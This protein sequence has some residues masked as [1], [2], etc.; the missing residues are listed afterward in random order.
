M[1]KIKS[2]MQQ[3][4]RSPKEFPVEMALGVVFFLIAVYGTHKKGWDA[5]LG[6]LTSVV[7]TDIL[8]F[9]VP[10]GILSFYLGKVN[11]WAYWLSFLLFIPLMALNLDPFIGSTAFLFTYVLAAILLVIGRRRM[12]NPSFGAHVLHVV[13]QGAFGV[14]ISG[15]LLLAL[16]AIFG[17]VEYIFGLDYG[18]L[19]LY[20]HI[21]QFVGFVV[22]PQICC[23]LIAHGEDEEPL[24]SRVLQ[25]IL[26]FIVSPAIIIY[27]V[28]LYVYF[29]KIAIEWDLPKGGVALMVMAFIAVS[30]AGRLLQEVL[31]RRYYDWFYKHFTWIALPP[32]LMYWIGSIYR[33]RHYSFTEGRFYLLV[34]GVLMTLFVLMLLKE[35]SRRFQLMVLIFGIAIIVFTYIPGISA[36]SIGFRC[37]ET[38][39]HQFID[40]LKL[41]D[42]KTGKFREIFD[43]QKIAR[44]SVLS[45]RFQEAI[46]IIEY[47]R[48][49]MGRKEFAKQ[50]GKWEL[51]TYEVAYKENAEDVSPTEFER[52]QA[53]DL[54]AYPQLLPKTAYET[55]Y[56]EGVVTVKMDE[57]LVMRYPID[58]LVQQRP[59]L[60]QKPDD[61][62][63]CRNDSLLLVLENVRISNHHVWDVGTWETHLFR[64]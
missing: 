15:L 17:S 42:P 46:S 14:V 38:R 52:K 36:K 31:P 47:V 40:E 11:R 41:N 56:S 64:K 6:S 34:A 32:L 33:I 60:L 45:S 4:L 8:A 51:T 48:A 18:P 35:R 53:V 20:E 37:Q 1:S 49:G 19:H 27:T 58:S 39:L 44:D 22:A 7:N 59:E 25:I 12:D 28:I 54:R 63:V 29:I 43:R 50:Y 26:N 61:I 21:W 2:L 13:T 57:R 24:T 3:L 62:F 10:L 23:T 16:M 30:L 5:A 9:F 55:R